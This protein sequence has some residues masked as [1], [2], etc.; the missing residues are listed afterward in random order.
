M[1]RIWIKHGLVACLA[2]QALGCASDK[3]KVLPH[4]PATMLDLWEEHTQANGAS[5]RRAGPLIA[6]RATL[7]QGPIPF[8]PSPDRSAIDYSRT[9]ENE[10]TA[11]FKRLPNPDLVMFVFPH[12]SGSEGAPIPGY[13]TIFPMHSRV[14]YALPG[15]RTEEY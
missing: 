2:L 6:A 3:E 4:E 15:E 10:I 1:P 7:R 12:L 13:S 9:S 14:K 8:S 11:Q 5:S